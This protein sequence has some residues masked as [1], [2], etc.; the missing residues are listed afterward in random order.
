[1]PPSDYSQSDL[2]GQDHGAVSPS[3]ATVFSPPFRAI[4]V[5]GAGTVVITSKSG[6]DATYTCPAGATIFMAGTK[7]K[8][9]S[10]ATLLVAMY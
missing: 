10:T 9:A 3:D 1:M 2:V 6:T 8:A 4:Y 5:G 7:V